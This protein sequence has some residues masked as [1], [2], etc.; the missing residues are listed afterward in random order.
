MFFMVVS[1]KAQVGVNTESPQGVFHIDA[2]RNTS[3]N[4]NVADDVVVDAQGRIGVGTNNPQ[5]KVEIRSSTQGGGFRLQDGSQ[6][7]GMV[8]TSDANGNGKWS[9]PG[10]S[11]FTRVEAK[12]MGISIPTQATSTSYHSVNTMIK[13][14]T[15]DETYSLTLPSYG[16]YSLTLGMHIVFNNLT[17]DSQIDFVIIQLLPRDDI[18]YW[19]SSLRFAGSYE[20][21]GMK[22]RE[23][24]YSDYRVYLSENI[25]LTPKIDENNGTGNTVY[26]SILVR[27]R[28]LPSPLLANFT[29]GS[30]S[31]CPQ[32]TGGSYV[33]IN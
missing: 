18:T 17:A 20:V 21:Y 15:T 3:G 13:D 30:H 27:G 2:A 28:N 4:T 14:I 8:L 6:G 25:T 32:C 12:S 24:L 29:I 1:L 16:T 5:T 19:D 26:F 7:S 22:S 33:R 11:E 9:A 23:S 10:F 31:S